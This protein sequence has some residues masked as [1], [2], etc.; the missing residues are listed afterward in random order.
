MVGRPPAS[1]DPGRPSVPLPAASPGA[2]AAEDGALG[3]RHLLL[4]TS[5]PL[6]SPERTPSR[7][8]NLETPVRPSPLGVVL[9]SSRAGRR[10]SREL[11]LRVQKQPSSF[12]VPRVTPW[13]AL[14]ILVHVA[15]TRAPWLCQLPGRLRGGEWNCV[16]MSHG[17][18]DP[19]QNTICMAGCR[20]HAGMGAGTPSRPSEPF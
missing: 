19:D 4:L 18:T 16:W 12:L 2:G 1:Q 3:R 9:L 6:L 15:S 13:R 20:G 10:T 11:G 14:A 7:A 8:L 5:R 17:K